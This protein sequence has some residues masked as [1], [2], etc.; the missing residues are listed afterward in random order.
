MNRNYGWVIVGAGLLMTCIAMGAMFSLPVIKPAISKAMGWSDAGVSTAMTIGFPIMGFAG[1]GWGA[2]SDKIG[3]KLVVLAGSIIL[4]LGLGLA[5]RADTL[6]EF[7]LSY[8]VLVGIGGGSFFPPLMAAVTGWFEKHRVLAVSLVSA[9]VGIAPLTMSP[10]AAWLI[11]HNDWRTTQLVLAGITLVALVP[12]AFLVRRPPAVA[13]DAPR[14]AISLANEPIMSAS[15]AFRSPQFIVLALTFFAC[16]ATHSGP[17]FHTVSYAETCGLPVLTAVSIYSI[18]GVGGLFGRVLIGLAGDRWGAKRVLVA[19]LLVQA[20]GAGAYFFVR[21]LEGFYSVAAIFGFAYGGVM[22]LYAVIAREYFGIRIMGTVIGA[23][24][25]VSALG[26]AL[27]P[28]LGGW[29]FDT[30][31]GYGWLYIASSA[32]GFGAAAIALAFPPF[33]SERRMDAFKPAQ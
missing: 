15:E 6:L 9:G 16:C 28:A 29:I 21:S 14:P 13:M 24:T 27:G 11:E 19:G 2:L 30:F 5:S 25:M 7:Q 33:P 26:M 3:P 32:I 20:I 4:A 31:G 18:E 17:I 23:A 22:P 10:F 12:M 8:G 1:F